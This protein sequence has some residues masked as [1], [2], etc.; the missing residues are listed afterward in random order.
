MTNILVIGGSYFAGRV[1]VEEYLKQNGGPITVF[2]RGR[3]PLGMKDVIELRGDRDQAGDL[4]ILGETSW[5]CVIDFCAY[6]KEQV[7]SLL[8]AL[9]GKIKHY[10]LISTTSVYENA[11]DEEIEEDG[12]LIKFDSASDK[13]DDYRLGKLECEFEARET[14]AKYNIPY[15][16]IRPSI[17]YGYYNYAPR[18]TAIF[19]SLAD[20]KP[21][22]LAK[23]CHARFSVIWVVDMAKLLLQTI[24]NSQMFGQ[25]FNLASGERISHR[26]LVETL[27]KIIGR[28]VA[29]REL[30]K[31]EI[32][33]GNIPMPFPLEDNLIYSNKKINQ[34]LPGFEYT[35]I[36]QGLRESL[37]YFVMVR[38]SKGQS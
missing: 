6:Q 13:Y 17:I 12:R 11:S 28:T 22:I 26:S 20:K 36:D 8:D 16:I 29:T 1:F 21:I 37:K 3:I 5:D 24:G 2:N 7:P 10:I 25:A 35:L 32:I 9:S 18:E 15:T 30:G 4:S 31:D 14:A 19:E 23:D 34:A 27:G 38:R 33:S